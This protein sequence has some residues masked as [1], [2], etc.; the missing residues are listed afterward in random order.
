MFSKPSFSSS[1]TRDLHR[2]QQLGHGFILLRLSHK[3]EQP[4]ILCICIQNRGDDLREENEQMVS[5]KQVLGHVC[6][7]S[8]KA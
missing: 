8:N 5:L 6:H 4:D 3:V 7:Y 1:I 2:Q